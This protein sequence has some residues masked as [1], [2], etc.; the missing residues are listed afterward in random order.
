L[1]T[2]VVKD[3]W[4]VFN[5]LY[6]SKSHGL[7]LPFSCSLHDALFL[8]DCDDKNRIS[9]YGASLDPPCTWGDMVHYTPKWVWSHCKRVIPPPEEL[10]PTVL[11]VFWTFG[12][13]KDVQTDQPLFN[14]AAW[15]AAK[16]ILLLIQNGYVSDL[17]G[18]PLYYIIGYDSKAGHLPIYHCI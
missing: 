13:L 15:C 8:P 18:I 1:C 14:T 16:N 6:I 10:Y 4:H 9:R 17:P 3:A 2:R 7:L 12:L 11:H 5:M